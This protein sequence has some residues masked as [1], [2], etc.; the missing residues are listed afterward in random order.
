MK[1]VIVI[2]AGG[3][4]RETLD[5]IEA[6]NASQRTEKLSI[7]GVL[8]DSPSNENLKLLEAR[9]INYLGKIND[10]LEG[11]E[12]TNYLVAVGNPTHRKKIS[13]NLATNNWKPLTVVH[14]SAVIGTQVRIGEGSIICAGV[15]ISTN[16][17]LNKHVHINP[18]AIIGHDT[19]LDDYVSIN[20]GA[21]ISGNVTIADQALIGAGSTVLQGLK[22]DKK[23]IVGAGSCVVK[24]VETNKIVKG[25]PAI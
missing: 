21:I 24:N 5:V 14:P 25:I 23:A 17:T 10:Y 1:N 9:S 15:L 12:S 2:G 13:E 7:H 8:D 19:I 18:G 6:H 4:G 16:V 11:S 3:F 22:V 20:P